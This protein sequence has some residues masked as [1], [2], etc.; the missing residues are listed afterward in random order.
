MSSLKQF[1]HRRM[2]PR[3]T[4]AAIVLVLLLLAAGYGVFKLCNSRI[5]EA[6]LRALIPE[7]CSRIRQQRQTIIAAIEAYKSHFG[8]YPPDHVLRREPLAVD[9][10]TNTL[11]YE[12]AGVQYDRTN[13]FFAIKGLESAQAKFV[14]ELLGC[15]AFTNCVEAPA[16]P[17]RFLPNDFLPAGQFHDDPDV[18]SLGVLP[19]DGLDSELAWDLDI[20]SW[21]YVSTSPTNNPG[22]FDLWLEVRW[23]K[24][25][26]TVGNWQAAD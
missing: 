13:D 22:K 23:K 10:V 8:F 1:L 19:Y 16:H 20:S 9:A 14:K 12:L 24:Q 17:Q 3:D 5:R 11:F 6:R 7:V 15:T 21:R 18:Y 4:L 25:S 2:G 26:I